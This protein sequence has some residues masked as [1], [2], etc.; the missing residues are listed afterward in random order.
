MK[1][2]SQDP[3]IAS[4]GLTH[5]IP[6][7]H[8]EGCCVSTDPCGQGSASVQVSPKQNLQAVREK[9]M[10]IAWKSAQGQALGAV[11]KLLSGSSFLLMCTK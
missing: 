7:C 9:T 10:K 2:Y 1:Q 11:V 8:Q 3:G 6:V 5:C 4:D